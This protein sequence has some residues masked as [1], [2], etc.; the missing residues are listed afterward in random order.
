VTTKMT[1]IVRNLRDIGIAPN[2]SWN[3]DVGPLGSFKTPG[4]RNEVSRPT[5]RWRGE[6]L[7]IVLS[8]HLP[9]IGGIQVHEHDPLQPGVG[10]N[11]SRDMSREVC[12]GRTAQIEAKTEDIS[13]KLH[14]VLYIQLFTLY[15]TGIFVK[16]HRRCGPPAYGHDHYPST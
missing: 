10:R 9:A 2:R 3:R 1:T 15:N 6:D 4:C 13:R 5:R 16:C 11:M 7:E 14:A 12:K 8:A